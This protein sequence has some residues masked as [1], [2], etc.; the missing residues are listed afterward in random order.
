MSQK[1]YG[2]TWSIL[3]HTADS[4]RSLLHYPQHLTPE[5][6][7]SALWCTLLGGNVTLE[8]SKGPGFLDRPPA[9]CAFSQKRGIPNLP[10]A[11]SKIGNSRLKTGI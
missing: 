7:H 1:Q 9:V 6:D 10:C 2:G 3:S 11:T 5:S 8:E 4:V